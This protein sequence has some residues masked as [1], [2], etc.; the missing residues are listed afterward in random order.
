MIFTLKFRLFYKRTKPK[1]VKLLVNVSRKIVSPKA[2]CVSEITLA[3]WSFISR[4]THL[5]L[6]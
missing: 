4:A 2:T 5:C 3:G 6:S 1:A